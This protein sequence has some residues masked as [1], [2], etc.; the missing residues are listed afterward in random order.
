M[1]N[2]E[3]LKEARTKG[4]LAQM[5]YSN[6]NSDVDKRAVVSLLKDFGI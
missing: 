4:E 2:L 6:W 3:F 5:P 1:S